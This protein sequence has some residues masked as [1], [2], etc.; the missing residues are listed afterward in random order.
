MSSFFNRRRVA[1]TSPQ[2]KPQSSNEALSEAARVSGSPY[3]RYSINT[4]DIDLSLPIE[5]EELGKGKVWPP[6]RMIDRYYRTEMLRAVYEG[7]LSEVLDLAELVDAGVSPTNLARRIVAVQ[8]NL[9]MRLPPMSASADGASNR[10]LKRA[11]HRAL[12]DIAIHGAAFVELIGGEWRSVDSRRVWW[13]TD[14]DWVTVEPRL[15][16]GSNRQTAQADSLMITLHRDGAATRWFQKIAQWD[17]S[18][19]VLLGQMQIVGDPGEVEELG[20]SCFGAA[21]RQPEIEQGGWG[22][23]LILDLISL[24]AQCALARARDTEVI[25]KHS[26]PILVLRGSLVPYS[27]A[28]GG[29]ASLVA[30][31]SGRGKL[32]SEILDEQQTM[33]RLLRNGY[34]NFPDGSQYAEYITWTGNLNASMQLQDR[35]DMELRLMNG[36][37]AML[38]DMGNIPSGMSLKRMFSLAD[39]EAQSVRLPL[40]DALQDCDESVVWDDAFAEVDDLNTEMVEDEASA[41]RGTSEASARR[42]EVNE[43]AMEG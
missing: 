20:E 27:G 31:A 9:M 33:A 21:Y 35:I 2:V 5:L 41:R 30:K 13:T 36:V 43:D 6:Q 7:D 1:A 22:S 26:R 25:E 19:A 18:Q 10:S 42:G 11:A 28:A 38:G 23:S 24:I 12:H 8:S 3:G 34:L 16:G 39:A 40:L 17:A 37:S 32:P 14:G 15:T 4:R 29:A